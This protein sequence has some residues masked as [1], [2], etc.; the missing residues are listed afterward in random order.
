MR[1]GEEGKSSARRP[2]REGTHGLEGSVA[3]FRA[4]VIPE[5]SG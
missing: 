3:Q 2:D 4:K 1:T 5:L